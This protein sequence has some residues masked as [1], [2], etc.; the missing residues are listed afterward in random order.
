[1]DVSPPVILA[2]SHIMRLYQSIQVLNA[3]WLTRSKLLSDRRARSAAHAEG[4]GAFPKPALGLTPR[5]HEG[6][7]DFSGLGFRGRLQELC[8]VLECYA[9]M[10]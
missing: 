4:Q 8:R 9:G 6:V 10:M 3:L 7:G 2:L 1:M 5:S